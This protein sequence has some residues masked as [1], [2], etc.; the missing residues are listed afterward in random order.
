M[1]KNGPSLKISQHLAGMVVSLERNL[2]QC[3]ILFSAAT[4]KSCIYVGILFLSLFP[5]LLLLNL[6][7]M[8][9][10]YSFVVFNFLF[11][12]DPF[13]WHRSELVWCCW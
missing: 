9:V 6:V 5:L 4:V 7:Y 12:N 8:L 1:F 10:F 3:F 2:L 11:H 13:H